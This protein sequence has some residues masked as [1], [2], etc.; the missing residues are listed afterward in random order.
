MGV[1]VPSSA[2]VTSSHSVW[3]YIDHIH[4]HFLMRNPQ[5]SPN[6]PPK[7]RDVTRTRVPTSW[8][9]SLQITYHERTSQQINV[10][11][12]AKATRTSNELFAWYRLRISRRP[13]EAGHWQWAP[14][15]SCAVFLE[16]NR[17]G[18]MYTIGHDQPSLRG[19][20]R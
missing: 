14:R 12:C 8:C 16:G 18:H 11:T 10:D 2:R 1:L 17:E 20:N 5:L 7:C 19:Q 13:R 4:L 9:D 6:P 3:V 15:C